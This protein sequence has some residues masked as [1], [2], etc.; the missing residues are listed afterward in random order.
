MSGAP[1]PQEVVHALLQKEDWDGAVSFLSERIGEVRED[2][3]LSWNLGWAYLKLYRF[4]DAIQW[5]TRATHLKPTNPAAHW[6]LGEVYGA[7]ARNE[8]A[9]R[10]FQFSLVMRDSYQSRRALGFLY[11]RT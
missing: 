6:A 3:E 4:D 1:T 7:S 9:E 11:H 10:E 2:F 8:E 5:L